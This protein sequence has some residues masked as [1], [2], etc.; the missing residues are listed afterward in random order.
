VSEDAI[1]YT[2]SGPSRQDESSFESL[3]DAVR[4]GAGL[5]ERGVELHVAIP[6]G[7]MQVRSMT[8]EEREVFGREY[9]R[10]TGN[11]PPEIAS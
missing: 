6:H 9:E 3:E 10:Q 4:F 8:D 5:V 1:T 2:V 7:P 11:P